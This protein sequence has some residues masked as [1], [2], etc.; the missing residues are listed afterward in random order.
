MLTTGVETP[1]SQAGLMYIDMKCE[2]GQKDRGNY[3]YAIN[4][5][6]PHPGAG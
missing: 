4:K 6:A 2:S 5:G 3:G 1:F